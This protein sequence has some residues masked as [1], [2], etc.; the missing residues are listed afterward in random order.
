MLQSIPSCERDAAASWKIATTPVCPPA[1]LCRGSAFG[2]HLGMG[3]CRPAHLVGVVFLSLGDCSR[4][5]AAPG[6]P[7]ARRARPL[8]CPLNV[9]V[10]ISSHRG[11]VWGRCVGG[12]APSPHHCRSGE[13]F[14]DARVDT[15]RGEASR[16]DP[17]PIVRAAAT[18]L[19]IG[20][21]DE[22]AR[23][24]CHLTRRKKSR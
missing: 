16:V 7:R 13:A 14:F 4:P 1:L 2:D 15:L 17:S 10:V 18:M 20:A 5:V 3:A 8:S 23:E 24:A 9:L 12:R 11:G 19:V 21:G 6:R 22:A